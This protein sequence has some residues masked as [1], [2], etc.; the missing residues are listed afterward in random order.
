MSIRFTTI[1]RVSDYDSGSF[2]ML[3]K[4][5]FTFVIKLVLASIMGVL[6]RLLAADMSF[7]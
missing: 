3:G 4:S 1:E 6:G 7:H 5:E 2:E